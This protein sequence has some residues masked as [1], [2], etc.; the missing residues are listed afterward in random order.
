[1]VPSTHRGVRSRHT[2]RA[3]C[4]LTPAGCLLAAG[5]SPTLL[6]LP[7]CKLQQASAAL[8]TKPPEV[9]D[10]CPA[11]NSR[12][13]S[14]PCLAP[15]AV[16]P[17]STGKEGCR[18]APLQPCFRPSPNQAKSSPHSLHVSKACCCIRSNP[19]SVVPHAE[20]LQPQRM[21][22]VCHAL[23]PKC[24]PPPP[25]NTNSM[26]Q[27]TPR[28]HKRC[29]GLSAAPSNS[30]PE[31][32]SSHCLKTHLAHCC[33]LVDPKRQAGM[34]LGPNATRQ[35]SSP[36]K[37]PR[38]QTPANTRHA[39]GLRSTP[40]ADTTTPPH[41]PNQQEMFRTHRHAHKRVQLQSGCSIHQGRRVRRLPRPTG[42]MQAYWSGPLLQPIAA[43]ATEVSTHHDCLSCAQGN[44]CLPRKR[45]CTTPRNSAYCCW[46]CA[47]AMLLLSCWPAA[48]SS[49]PAISST[50]CVHTALPPLLLCW[51]CCVGCMPQKAPSSSPVSS[52]VGADAA[53]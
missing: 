51:P 1:M 15:C 9:L 37:P 41:T 26:H 24:T 11:R 16:L 39:G 21:Q 28:A 33:M 2:Q 31:G 43:A 48:A 42:P 20:A 40:T 53:V 5:S 45:A 25:R 47:T 18:V 46:A 29:V 49:A 8:V 3:R 10:S 35:C 34:C 36:R 38:S 7:C 32:P 17:P 44:K 30:G 22:K 6:S 14:S 4:L 19:A 52:V 27:R 13:C 23:P 50:C 12:Q